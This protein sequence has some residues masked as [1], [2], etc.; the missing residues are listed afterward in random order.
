[1]L[2]S[3]VVPIMSKKKVLYE[4]LQ[5]CFKTTERLSLAVCG[6]VC[7]EKHF[8]KYLSAFTSLIKKVALNKS[9]FSSGFSP[10]QTW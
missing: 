2:V 8:L 3:V 5:E 10:F 1:M 6:L 7:G 9:K 4:F